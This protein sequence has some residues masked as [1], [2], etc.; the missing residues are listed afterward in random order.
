[1]SDRRVT[2]TTGRV[3]EETAIEQ[4]RASL[5]GELMRLGDDGYHTARKVGTG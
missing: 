2:S 3:V 5:R 1:M 4:F